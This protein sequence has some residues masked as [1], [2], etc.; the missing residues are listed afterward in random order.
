M[1]LRG[2]V[3]ARCCCRVGRYA[4]GT[5]YL[6]V[7]L[8]SAGVFF[9][10]FLGTQEV[11]PIPPPRVKKSLIPP[12]RYSIKSCHLINTSFAQLSYDEAL[13]AVYPTAV[14]AVHYRAF[15]TENTV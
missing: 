10:F 15:P 13:A 1:C 8:Q 5:Q 12:G 14:A 4:P 11:E 7:L 3:A 9:N 6:L 2:P